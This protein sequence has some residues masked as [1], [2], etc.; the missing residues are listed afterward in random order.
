MKGFS[1]FNRLLFILNIFPA[2]L[3]VL[4]CYIAYFPLAGLPLLDV[5]G[6]LVP[7]LVMANIP[8]L[9]YWS[10]LKKWQA[11]LSFLTLLLGLVS[12]GS[13]YQSNKTSVYSPEK[14]ISVMTY[15]VKGFGI[16]RGRL[17][18]E[19]ANSGILEFI[20]EENPDIICIQ[21]FSRIVARQL[22]AYPYRFQTPYFSGKTT[23]AIFSKYPIL[24]GGSLDFP[25]SG[26]NALFADIAYEKDTLRIYNI[27]LESFQIHSF[28]SLLSRNLGIDFLK[29]LQYTASKHREQADLLMAHK[30]KSPYPSIFTG[31]FNQTPYSPTFHKLQSGMRDTFKEKGN[32]WG[33][34]FKRNIISARVD[35]ILTD[36]ERF[37]V[38]EH[39]NFDLQH[40]DHL[41]VMARVR[42][43]SDE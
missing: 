7:V 11:I 1:A 29:R 36:A 6:L 38:I 24:N 28:S 22:K 13:V 23:Q 37:E 27:H 5:L 31:D 30:A 3:L 34:T 39:Q 21:E 33:T 43:R 14:D 26:N 8:F 15:N 17:V 4:T 12:F 2:A 9:I 35:F 32:G 19:E 10:L 20:R 42:L 18:S 40:S 25:N 41:P 16:R